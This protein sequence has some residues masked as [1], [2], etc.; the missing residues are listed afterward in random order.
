M[1]QFR[2]QLKYLLS[3]GLY[4]LMGIICIQK[5]LPWFAVEDTFVR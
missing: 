2:P 5:F 1:H 3:I 4:I